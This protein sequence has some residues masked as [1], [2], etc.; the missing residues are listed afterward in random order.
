MYPHASLEDP[1]Y[2]EPPKPKRRRELHGDPFAA[3]IGN[4]TLL[5]IGYLLLGRRRAAAMTLVVTIW[6]VAFVAASPQSPW[7]RIVL[8]AWWIATMLHTFWLVRPERGRAP[9]AP[10]VDLHEPEARRRGRVF[11]G[12][13]VCLMAMAVVGIRFDGAQI[14]EAAEAAHRDGDCE[15]ATAATASLDATHRV[16]DAAVVRA[17]AENDEACEL[18]LAAFDRDDPLESA[19]TLQSYMEQP[20]AL[21][22]G[23]GPA[24]ADRL[25]RGALAPLNEWSIGIVRSAFD[26]LASTLDASPDQS[27]AA[28]EVVEGFLENLADHQAEEACEVK[29]VHD[30]LFNEHWGHPELDEPVAAVGDQVPPVLLGCAREQFEGGMLDAAQDLY[31]QFLADFPDHELAPEA[32]A[33]L[34]QVET[35]I[36]REH[37]SGLLSGGDY[38]GSPAPYRAAEPYDEGG[39]NPMWLFGLDSEADLPGSW[40]TNAVD[41]TVLVVCVEGPE[42]GSFIES[43]EYEEVGTGD[44]L[45]SVR[46]YANEFT[47]E[48]YELKTGERIE[49]YSVE[50]G[51]EC[52]YYLTFYGGF[53]NKQNVSYSPKDLRELFERLQ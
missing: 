40:T 31:G 9:E 7:W 48:A 16:A 6:L 5:G 18:L 34:E 10:L 27:A 26:V 37:V 29:A 1:H 11:A 41:E 22:E 14:M 15:G 4:A 36:E 50:L 3:L 21:W 17:A 52:P 33:E 8:A 35:A 13:V 46:F 2:F 53:E 44:Y 20:G 30:W 23:A 38:C 32:A 51:G 43:C 19:E 42:R 28:R 49:R 12:A 47:V 39:T 45:G 25:L 24:R